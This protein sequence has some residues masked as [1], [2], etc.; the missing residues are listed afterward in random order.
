MTALVVPV[1][2]GEGIRLR[3]FVTTDVSLIIDAGQDP[4]IPLITTV[5][6]HGDEADGQAFIRRQHQR[7]AAAEGWSFAVSDRDTDSA[8]GQIGLWRRDI[9]HGRASAGYWIGPGYRRC[10]YAVRAL[11]LLSSW[12]VTLEEVSRLELYVEPWNEGS[13]RAAESAG[14]QREGLLRRWQKIAG[15]P[16]DMYMYA[17][18]P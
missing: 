18:L 4:L 5:V 15:E 13:W 3:P 6:A 11:R 8:V 12:A 7:A 10:G 14:Y 2:E 17:L 9:R 1:L 16:R